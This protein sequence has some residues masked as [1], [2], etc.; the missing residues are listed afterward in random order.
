MEKSPRALQAAGVDNPAALEFDCKIGNPRF[1][2]SK[3]G[4]V[5]IVALIVP[6]EKLDVNALLRI[7][8]DATVAVSLVPSAV[9]LAFDDEDDDLPRPRGANGHA[10]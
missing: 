6:S 1:A 3:S 2:S 10:R 8:G 4:R 5:A 9:Q 7:G